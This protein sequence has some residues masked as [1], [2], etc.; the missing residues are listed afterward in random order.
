MRQTISGL[1]AA[2]AVVAASA[3][4]AMAC[5]G[6]GLFQ[7]VLAMRTGTA[8]VRSRRFTCLR[9]RPIRTATAAAAAGPMSGCPIR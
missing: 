9:R 2:I 1:V 8:R 7:F 3:V 6:G 5:G 4:P